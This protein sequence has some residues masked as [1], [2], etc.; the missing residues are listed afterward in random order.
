[1]TKLLTGAAARPFPMVILMGIMTLFNVALVAW[2]LHYIQY[3]FGQINSLS[4]V[5]RY[6]GN[7]TFFFLL[8][9]L[10]LAWIPFWVA[11]RLE[12]WASSPLRAV[13]GLALWLVFLPNAPYL[14][15]DLL[16]LRPQLPVPFWYDVLMI[17]SFGWTGL[18][19]GFLSLQE[20]RRFLEKRLPA[21]QVYGLEFVFIFLCGLGVFI[22]RFQRYNS[23]DVL[24]DPLGLVKDVAGVLL[25]PFVHLDQLGLAVV[26]S[27]LIF[28]GH[29]LFRAIIAGYAPN[30]PQG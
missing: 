23:W 20:V 2:R 17:F 7:P 18:L 11:L 5:A 27:I 3:D 26:L 16:H 24:A 6:R 12:K 19:L 22:G 10:F 9:N 15:T 13:A 4:D 29:W 21:W 25:H 8:W 14:I 30:P 28:L 1:M